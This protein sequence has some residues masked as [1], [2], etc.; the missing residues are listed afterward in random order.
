MHYTY[1]LKSLIRKKTYVGYT[2]NITKRFNDHN[3]G[4]SIYTK[5]YKPWK[6]IH[7]E[8]FINEEEAIKKEKY[9]KSAA[10][11]RWMKKFLFS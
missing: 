5:R 8:K 4:K 1:I 3:K 6:I 7:L 11:R 9:F 2:D 10:G